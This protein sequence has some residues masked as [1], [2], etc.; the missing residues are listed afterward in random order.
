MKGFKALTIAVLLFICMVGVSS[1]V[2]LNGFWNGVANY[3]TPY[4]TVPITIEIFNY[5]GQNWAQWLN[6]V[7]LMHGSWFFGGLFMFGSGYEAFGH[8]QGANR[9]TGNFFDYH[10]GAQGTF[11]VNKKY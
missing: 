9:I 4:G 3:G 6:G 1:A 7:H 2:D 5:D 8:L 11:D 10:L